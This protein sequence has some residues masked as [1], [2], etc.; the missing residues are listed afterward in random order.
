MLT[1]TYAHEEEHWS[2]GVERESGEDETEQELI[3]HVLEAVDVLGAGWLEPLAWHLSIGCYDT[4]TLYSPSGC[5]PPK[6][7]WFLRKDMIPPGVEAK[8]VYAEP[9]VDTVPEFTRERTHAWIAHALEQECSTPARFIP[10]WRELWW[11]SVRIKLPDPPR[12]LDR[13]HL[14]V[15]CYAGTVSVPLERSADGL[16]VSGPLERYVI[17]PPAALTVYN[18]DGIIA[19]YLRLYWNL[20][21]DDPAGRDQVEAAVGRVLALGRGW[22]RGDT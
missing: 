4:E 19:I 21:I 15:D 1:D 10:S 16:W 18:E 3:G 2:L 12:M 9:L 13:D 11:P 22:R 7:Q 20:W 14:Q 8:H 5:R 17:G 6:P